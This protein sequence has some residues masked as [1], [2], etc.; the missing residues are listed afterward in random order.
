MTP[1]EEFNNRFHDQHKAR[2]I[3]G[4]SFEDSSKSVKRKKGKKKKTK[5]PLIS[6]PEKYQRIEHRNEMDQTFDSK[7]N[8]SVEKTQPKAL[9]KRREEKPPT[10]PNDLFVIE[11]YNDTS[12]I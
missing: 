6:S 10:D 4:R 11:D 1:L 3:V 7:S 2:A 9:K 8:S 5:K 12:Q